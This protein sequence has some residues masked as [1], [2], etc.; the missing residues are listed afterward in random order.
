MKV[1]WG[2]VTPQ[3]MHIICHYRLFI[4][5]VNNSSTKVVCL[6]KCGQ[7]MKSV[8]E[9][10]SGV[11]CE[12][13]IG[14]V[15]HSMTHLWHPLKNC[16]SEEVTHTHTHLRTFF[17]FC[18]YVS[19]CSG[20]ETFRS[21]ELCALLRIYES[22]QCGN[23]IVKLFVLS[24]KTFEDAPSSQLVLHPR[25][26]HVCMYVLHVGARLCSYVALFLCATSA[27][28]FHVS[29][30]MFTSSCVGGCAWSLW[31]SL[32][33]SCGPNYL[34]DLSPSLAQSPSSSRLSPPAPIYPPQP[35]I[36]PS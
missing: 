23:L 31:G 10:H 13:T 33:E 35:V 4:H 9:S 24:I 22:E 26:N 27:A 2:D 1:T 6:P 20:W 14:L 25:L 18:I 5:S 11:S 34:L 16:D 32:N 36:S 12:S 15:E 29:I 17:V 8:F 30:S 28:F 3:E 19:V 21:C 7:N